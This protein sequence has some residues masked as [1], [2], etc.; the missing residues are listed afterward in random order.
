MVF[1]TD[2]KPTIGETN[3]EKILENVYDANTLYIPIFTLAFGDEADYDLVRKIANQNFGFSR[4]IYEDADAALQ[5]SGFYD[6]VSGLLLE[7]VEF[8]Y[9]DGTLY[10]STV[11]DKRFR[12]YFKGT[13]LIVS[14]HVQNIDKLQQG[15]T[16]QGQSYGHKSVTMNYPPNECTIL[17]YKDAALPVG[18]RHPGMMEKLWAYL[19]IKQ[20]LQKRTAIDVLPEIQQIESEIIRISLRVC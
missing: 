6:E 18:Q 7:D 16:I 11:T 8:K 5:I 15:M 4:K 13:E 14:G 20:L 10:E 3:P 17:P 9:L 2:G 1:L 12:N 19:T